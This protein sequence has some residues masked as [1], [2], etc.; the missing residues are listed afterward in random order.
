MAGSTENGSGRRGNRW[1]LAVW[2]TAALLLVLPLLAMQFTEEVAWGLSD[3]ALFGAMLFVACGTYEL[4]ARMTGN[5]A[6]RAAV[7]VALAAAFILVWMNLAV[8]LIGSE[9]NPANLMYGG[10]LVVG[11]LGAIIARFRPHGMALSLVGTALAQVLVVVIALI[12]GLA[13]NLGDTL[14]LTGFFVALWLTSARLFR[15]AAR[16]QSPAGAAP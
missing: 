16:E 8:G 14:M 10:V 11:I 15:K 9:E 6:Y 7:G 2:G 3:F 1:R 5:K 4:A 12:V 13:Y